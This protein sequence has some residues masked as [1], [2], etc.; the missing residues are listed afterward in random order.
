MDDCNGDDSLDSDPAGLSLC[1]RIMDDSRD[2][3]AIV[4]HHSVYR[5][6]SPAFLAAFDSTRDGLIGRRIDQVHSPGPALAV[7]LAD[8]E[9]CLRG[10]PVHRLI[11]APHASAGHT[12]HQSSYALHYLPWYGTM[13]AQRGS[14]VAVVVRL[15]QSR[16]D[17]PTASTGSHQ[18]AS[19]PEVAEQEAER[20]A[21]DLANEHFTLLLDA[22]DSP[23]YVSDMQTYELLYVNRK[24]REH[25]GDVR[26]KLCYQTIQDSADGPC[27]FCTNDRLLDAD[28]QPTEPYIWDARN[29]RLDRWFHCIDR[30]IRWDDGRLVRLEIA[31]DITERKQAEEA[32]AYRADLQTTLARVSARLLEAG[33]NELTAVV[34][35]SMAEMRAHLA[36]DDAFLALYD[37]TG[38]TVLMR[39]MGV[40]DTPD[41]SPHVVAAVDL[42]ALLDAWSAGRM[43]LVERPEPVGEEI[44]QELSLL[45]LSQLRSLILAPLRGA[46][47][48][49]LAAGFGCREAEHAWTADEQ[50]VVQML[51]SLVGNAFGRQTVLK[52][53]QSSREHLQKVAF[54]DPLTGLANRR[55]LVERMREA[56][57]SADRGGLMFA[58][59]YVDLD[60]F[61]P[62]NDQCGHEAGDQLLVQV[63][64]RL[65]AVLRPS[66]TVARWGGDEFALLLAD[67]PGIQ[68]CEQV[69]ERLRDRLQQPYPIQQRLF[70]V[71]ASIG[72]SL[73]PTDAPDGEALLRCADQALYLAKQAGRNR[74][75]FFDLENERAASARHAHLVQIE[76]AVAQNELCLRYQP[77]FDMRQG[78]LIGVEALV[79]WQHPQRGLL[80]PEAFLPLVE[81]DDLIRQVDFWVI[82]MALRDL[83]AWRAKGLRLRLSLN[84]GARTLMTAGF[85]ESVKALLHRYP[86]IAST[87]IDLEVRET[88]AIHD[89][90]TIAA[91]VAEAEALGLCFVIDDF[92]KGNASLSAFRHLGAKALKI[93]QSLIDG[94]SRDQGDLS[95]VA[96]VIGVARAFDCGVV[97][98]GLETPEQ[99]ML[100]LDLGCELAQGFYIAHPME[101]DSIPAWVE[102]YTPP[103]QWA[104]AT[105]ERAS[106]EVDLLLLEP[107]QQA[108]LDQFERYLR[109]AADA[110]LQPRSLLISPLAR[111]LAGDAADN[112]ASCAAFKPIRPLH[113]SLQTAELA[114][115]LCRERDEPCLPEMIDALHQANGRLVSQLRR[116]RQEALAQRR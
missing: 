56:T 14:A 102:S 82:S 114:L 12:S 25:F 115:V 54:S 31:I 44:R 104:S 49:M 34:K 43:L 27:S 26:G 107:R 58:V 87:D 86:E 57:V 100:L 69:L 6:A 22:I 76:R 89:L 71:T 29:T 32:A 93:D 65:R 24:V 88:A 67:L 116:L 28:G 15:L 80:A 106:A 38:S 84:V 64:D 62:V 103:T 99:G 105:G 11:S 47:D 85:L 95:Q 60:K 10:E 33:Q 72:V 79:R 9:R 30:A 66:D 98:E 19:A 37:K 45:G 111:W 18:F 35:Q 59:C 21:V 112:Y 50:H 78:R 42:P 101:A 39:H 77:I 51:A 63:A 90:D 94:M 73:Y 113:E 40:D 109:H 108:W 68:G 8:V 41:E 55:L 17:A 3:V 91:V 96:S 48:L 23:V 61:K 36:A 7:S 1:Q 83:A 81:S 5:V 20:V 2:A 75:Q 52:A 74:V 16:D 53:L 13:P 46:A 97:A 4:D 70:Q 110:R 92:G